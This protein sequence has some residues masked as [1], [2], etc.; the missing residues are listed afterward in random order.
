MTE[1]CYGGLNCRSDSVAGGDIH[2]IRH[3]FAAGF[4]HANAGF[5]GP[6][7]IRVEDGQPRAFG[8]QACSDL[9]TDAASAAG[10]QRDLAFEAAS[11]CG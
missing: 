5:L 11:Q 4:L 9:L 1:V 8:G 3:S 2:A 7:D 10:D 6:C